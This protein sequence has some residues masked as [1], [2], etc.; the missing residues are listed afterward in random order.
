MRAGGVLPG[1]K[2][3]RWVGYRGN[4]ELDLFEIKD[5]RIGEPQE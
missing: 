3:H 5:V 2:K 4:P 1:E